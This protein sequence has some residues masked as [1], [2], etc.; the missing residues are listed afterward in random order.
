MGTDKSKEFTPEIS[1]IKTICQPNLSSLSG[2]IAES[3]FDQLLEEG[4][5]RDLPIV[6]SL[7]NLARTGSTI[8]E[9]LFLKKIL[10]FLYQLKD[11]SFE[12]RYQFDKQ[13]EANPELQ[14]RVGENLIL[15]LHRLD[16]MQKPNLLGRIFKAYINDQIDYKTYEKLA[17]AVDRI[18]MQSLAGLVEFYSKYNG[19]NYND[20]MEHPTLP[21]DVIQ[22]LI[23]CGLIDIRFMPGVVVSEADFN[24]GV[25]DYRQTFCRHCLE[26]NCYKL[27]VQIPIP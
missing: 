27:A 1:L 15:W 2:D 6:G 4:F 9:H 20:L 18:K 16:D 14:Q 17:I 10:R 12:K 7:A 23:L 19:T 13:L 21:H 11:L 25:T 5:I 24:S 22:D 3:L 26:W 8:R